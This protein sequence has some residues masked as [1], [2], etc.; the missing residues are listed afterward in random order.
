MESSR[1][2]GLLAFAPVVV[3]AHI[4]EENPGLVGWYNRH[5]E[6][7]LSMEE[8][9]LY[10]VIGLLATVMPVASAHRSRSYALGLA[11]FAWLGFVMLA[12]GVL[13]FTACVV[14]SE[15]APGSITA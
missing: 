11:L 12:N 15:Y 6:G 5:V 10:D 1:R 4:A 14:F 8:F 13:H 3:L 9:L 7:G 2:A